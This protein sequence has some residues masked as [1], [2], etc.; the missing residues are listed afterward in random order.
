MLLII[1]GKMCSGKDT[2]VKR[3]VNKGF[4]RIVPYT[5]RPKRKNETEGVDYHFISKQDFEKKIDSG[6]FLEYRSYIPANGDLW[7]YGSSL[8]DYLNITDEQ[9]RVVI[10]NPDGVDKIIT[11]KKKLN[12]SYKV[13][14]VKTNDATI[15]M[16]AKMRGDDHD[17]LERRIV[18]D[19]TS[20]CVMDL[21]A[22]QIVWN[23]D[24]T[25][26]KD[27]VNEIMKAC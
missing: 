10:L 8:Q 16:R 20:Y 5:T 18:A 9:K 3:I 11:N 14:Y 27:V 6:F 26:I 17:E 24:G 22:D 25:E 15:R 23:N 4:K 19:G 2:I 1:T 12:T 21:F 13:I 7:Y